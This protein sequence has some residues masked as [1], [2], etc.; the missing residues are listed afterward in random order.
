MQ[1]VYIWNRI[2]ALTP[3]NNAEDV[4]SVAWYRVKDMDVFFDTEKAHARMPANGAD[5]GGRTAPQVMPTSLHGEICT[6]DGREIVEGNTPQEFFENPQ[7]ERT[8]LFLS[9]ILH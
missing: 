5:E 2:I 3:W 1:D 6:G 7:H 4:F 8:K 9:Q